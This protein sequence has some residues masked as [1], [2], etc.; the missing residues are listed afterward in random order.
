MAGLGDAQTGL[1]RLVVPHLAHQDDIRVLAQDRTERI[2]VRLGVDVE[3]P[4][5]DDGLAGAEIILD[6]VLDGH[7]VDVPLVVDVL[8]HAGQARRLAA[9][10]RPGDEDEP[11]REVAEL[12]D[13]LG[14]AELGE[15]PHVRQE[16]P[17]GGGDGALLHEDVRPEA[18]EVLHPE[19]EVE[20]PLLLEHLLLLVGQ[21]AVDELLGLGRREG[22]VVDGLERAVD[23][24]PRRD[25]GR[26]MEVARVGVDR[27]LQEFLDRFCHVVLP[28]AGRAAR[29]Q[30]ESRMV[31]RK[32][33]S[34]EVTPFM[35]LTRPLRRSVII[36]ASMA[37]FLIS[38]DWVRLRIM[39]R[40]SSSTGMTS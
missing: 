7:D 1:D 36:P 22:R 18:A 23:P 28:A 19:R 21:D 13:P 6:R 14:D 26:D 38:R 10:G 11:P 30:P 2:P 20:L 31:S 15:A 34:T 29:R 4:L 24:D 40:M 33:S 8:D 25:V 9:A 17:E 37:F 16:P 3:L 32:T 27:H 39:S 5:V 35:I 12:G